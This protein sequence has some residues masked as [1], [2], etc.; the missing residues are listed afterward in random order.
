M[1]TLVF[2][3]C[4]ALYTTCEITVSII[5]LFT[6]NSIGNNKEIT[7]AYRIILNGKFK[8]SKPFITAYFSENMIRKSK[9]NLNRCVVCKKFIIYISKI[10]KIFN[11]ALV[12]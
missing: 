6:N 8:F 2:P 9:C 1:V 12:F 5:T 10:N 4:S 3:T 7:A 11:R